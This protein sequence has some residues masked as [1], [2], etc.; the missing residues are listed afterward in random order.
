MKHEHFLWERLRAIR[1]GN[2]VLYQIKT[3]FLSL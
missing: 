2:M 1:K 3:L